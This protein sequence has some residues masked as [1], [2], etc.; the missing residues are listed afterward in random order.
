[1]GREGRFPPILPVLPILPFPPSCLGVADIESPQYET[2]DRCRRG[3]DR[4]LRSD[5]GAAGDCRSRGAADRRARRSADCA[6]GRSDLR[7]SDRGRWK[8]RDDSGWRAR[9]RSR[10]RDAAAG[11]HRSPHAS[12]EHRHSLGRGV[13]EDDTRPGG[14][15]WRTQRVHHAD[16]RVHELP[17]HG[18]DVAVHRYRPAK[19]D[20]RRDRARPAAHGVGQLRV[21]DRRRRRC[22]PVLDL[23]RRTDRQEPRRWSRRDPQSGANEPEAGRRFHQDSRHRRGAVERHSAG[24]A[25]LHRRR[26]ARCRRRSGEMGE[27]R[28]GASARHRRHQGRHPRWRAHGRSRQ[29]HGRRGGRAAQNTSCVLRADALHERIDFGQRERTG[30]RKGAVARDQGVEGPLVPNGARGRPAHRLRDRCRRRSARRERARVRLS[31]TA[32]TD[33]DGRDSVGD[34]DRRGD[35]GMERPRRDD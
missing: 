6:G 19:G 9:D 26:D 31:R 18:T 10:I 8:R 23:R 13:V 28:R 21:A 4:L 7:R 3:G 5:C 16:G 22:A 15:A 32:R 30:V 20:R 2:S 24:R 35:H 12:D 17:R 27:A 14:A 25:V 1:M 29:H 33:A 34:E 11:P